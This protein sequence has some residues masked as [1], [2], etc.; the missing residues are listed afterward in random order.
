[1]TMGKA[2]SG[3]G[4]R[5]PGPGATAI[6]SR[7]EAEDGRFDQSFDRLRAA[8][9]EACVGQ[10]AWEGKIGSGL[11]AVLEFVAEEPAAA[12][13]LTDRSMRSS[14]RA[15]EV[16]AYFTE[17]LADVAPAS[18]RFA[19]ATD[20]SI[21]ECVATLVRGHLLGE[22]TGRLPELAPELVAMAL[23]PYSGSEAAEYW[24]N[25]VRDA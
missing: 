20:E 9:R 12:R 22:S 17:L 1:M 11:R 4:R 24:S 14:Q 15:D 13:E 25:R 19:L 7:G 10:E 2:D 5:G 18:R 21:V 23:M 3:G 16:I 8:V 6:S